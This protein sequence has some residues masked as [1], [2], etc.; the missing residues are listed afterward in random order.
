[1]D[2]SRFTPES[3][4][5]WYMGAINGILHIS[6]VPET[7]RRVDQ[8]IN[9]E[10]RAIEQAAAHSTDS[11]ILCQDS[12]STIFT[13][14]PT[15]KR[16]SHAFPT[17]IVPDTLVK[18]QTDGTAA[19]FQAEIPF[20][21]YGQSETTHST[22]VHEGQ[23]ALYHILERTGHVITDPTL[24]KDDAREFNDYK[25]EILSRMIAGQELFGYTRSQWSRPGSMD[26]ETL[27]HI[28]MLNSA[29][30]AAVHARP[31]RTHQDFVLATYAATNWVELY[32]GVLEQASGSS[33][34][35][36]QLQAADIKFVDE[37]AR[38]QFFKHLKIERLSPNHLMRRPDGSYE[39]I[40]C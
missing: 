23:H 32:T 3:F 21:V 25:G 24:S 13:Q 36:R 17:Y 11:E 16:T 20:I 34:S 33:I 5:Q 12:Y 4:S 19:F 2:L 39:H 10:L 29:I 8:D 14:E 9:K 35:T 28:V 40:T 26:S 1:M 27:A 6:Q 38:Q 22:Q 15:L 37:R 7:E 30:P 18:R 31:D